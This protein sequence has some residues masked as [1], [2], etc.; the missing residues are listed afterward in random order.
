MAVLAAL[1]LGVVG[2]FAFGAGA[3]IWMGS[4]YGSNSGGTEMSSFF[5]FGPVGG[6]AGILLGV[7]LV[8]H[9]KGAHAG[10]AKGLMIGAAS[11]AGLALLALC[12]L[13]LA[14]TP[15]AVRVPAS[16]L[17]FQ[18]EVPANA[19]IE[20]SGWSFDGGSV[21]SVE[22]HCAESTCTL[23][24]VVSV[25]ETFPGT[26]RTLAAGGYRFALDAASVRHAADWCEWRSE[27]TARFRYRVN[28]D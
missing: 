17:V 16:T 3:A 9:F 26:A 22:K 18:L 5:T 8:L 20:T 7:G 28:R 2:C 23:V 1:I 11:L 24:F 10:W 15:P 4:V 14:H 19:P 27:G 25:D 13:A 12:G 21:S 6:L